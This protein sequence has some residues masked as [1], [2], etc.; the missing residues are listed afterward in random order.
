VTEA[1]TGKP[2]V[3]AQVS[4]FG[5]ITTTDPSGFYTLTNVPAGLAFV[6]ASA[7]GY[8]PA[9]R[10]AD[11]VVGV[12]TTGVDFTFQRAPLALSVAPA[13]ELRFFAWSSVHYGRQPTSRV[14]LG[15]D[16]V[17]VRVVP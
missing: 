8:T 14:C 17:A 10:T 13:V 6:E 15:P 9:N 16:D 12:T 4:A 2:I 3:G 11:V 7:G 1:G 5:T